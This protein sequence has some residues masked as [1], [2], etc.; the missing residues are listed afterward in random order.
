MCD[1]I[2]P[3]RQVI[4]LISP[5][6]HLIHI[7]CSIHCHLAAP[8]LINK[9][10]IISLYISFPWSQCIGIYSTHPVQHTPC[11][12]YTVYCIHQEQHTPSTAYTKYSIHWVQH[13]SINDI[14][15]FV[16][17][18][19][20]W[21]INVALGSNVPPYYTHRYWPSTIWKLCWTVHSSHS[22]SIELPNGWIES[23][24][25]WHLPINHLQ[26]LLQVYLIMASKFS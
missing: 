14:L 24:N 16:L 9:S 10:N 15:S 5:I 17:S 12:A 11:T 1:I 18:I 7:F 23:Q 26:L 20:S 19:T 3:T 13:P 2:N 22:H 21:P 25:P 4:C 8:F 6:S